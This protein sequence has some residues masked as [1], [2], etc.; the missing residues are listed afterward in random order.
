MKKVFCLLSVLLSFPALGQNNY[1]VTTPNSITPGNNNTLIGPSAGVNTTASDNTFIGNQAGNSNK[2]GFNNTYVGSLAGQ[3]GSGGFNNTFIGAFAGNSNLKGENNTFIGYAVGASNE[4]SEN[5]FVGGYSGRL[6]Y[7]GTSNTFLGYNAGYR[8]STGTRNTFIGNQAG[9]Y[10]TS[11]S[12]NIIIGPNSGTAITDGSDN[13]LMG[14]NSQA[15]EGIFNG[16][17]IGSNSRVAASNSLVLGHQVNVGIGTSAPASK[18]EIVADEI[19]QSG[20]RLSSL[21][22]T[23]RTTHFADQFLTVNEKGDVVKARYQLFINNPTEWSD[24]VFSPSYPLCSLS[25]VADYIDQHRHLPGIPS[26]EQI[27][28]EGIDPIKM[29]AM[30]LEK[31][32]ELTLYGIQLEKTNQDQ[33]KRLQELEQK[34]AKLERLLQQVLRQK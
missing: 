2:F 20:L 23:S 26:A 15:E 9:Y 13:I 29:N 30:L 3:I 27:V 33:Q 24:K 34:Q 1:V 4:G 31:V 6:N 8:N 18:L 16:V 7:S 32:E 22:S 12:N 28:K 5:V 10:N 11:G 17:A 19:G 14:Y 25:A 21:T